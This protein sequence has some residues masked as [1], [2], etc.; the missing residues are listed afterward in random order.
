MERQRALVRALVGVLAAFALLSP[1]ASAAPASTLPIEGAFE[2][3]RLEVAF[4]ACTQ[5]LAVMK[6]GGLRVV[7]MSAFGSSP[8]VLSRYAAAAHSL[9]MSVVWEISSPDWW[10]RPPTSVAASLDFPQFAAACGCSDNAHLLAY[11]VQQLGS[12]PGTY[13][14]Y[15]VDDSMIGP[16][17]QAGIAAYVAT[18]K[19]NDPTH[20]VMIGAFS[21]SQRQQYMGI[22]DLVGQEEYPVLNQSVLL[23]DDLGGVGQDAAYTQQEA[24]RAGKGSA[25]ILQ[26][27]TW[28]DNVADGQAMGVCTPSDT[29]STCYARLSYPTAAEQLALRNAVLL[30]AH[31]KLILWWSFQG[32]YGTPTLDTYSVFPTGAEAAARWAGLSAAL[33]AP[34]PP[35]PSAERK[36]RDKLARARRIARAKV[37]AREQLA[38]DKAYFKKHHRKRPHHGKAPT[39]RRPVLGRLPA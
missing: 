20:T 21:S 11:M 28:G 15:A 23:P 39:L 4:Q 18:I 5:R 7:V 24:D 14:Y 10:Q 37:Y 19:H 27:F 31:P 25:F 8:D 2:N 12:Q 6:Q 32:T 1:A 13:G 35:N 29:T 38:L 3:C 26:A 30:N 9:G 34:L 22:A 33:N 17:D 16:G 36:L